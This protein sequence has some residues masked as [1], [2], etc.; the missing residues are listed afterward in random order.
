M[1]LDVHQGERFV[2]I[3]NPSGTIDIVGSGRIEGIGEAVQARTLAAGL[4]TFSF[5][6]SGHSGVVEAS[7][8]IRLCLA[9]GEDL[10]ITFP[11]EDT[12]EDPP[13]GGVV[14]PTCGIAHS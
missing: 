9:S 13:S 12:G 6:K 14:C 7:G 10:T 4:R 3:I 8:T 2:I 11:G 1:R 5:A